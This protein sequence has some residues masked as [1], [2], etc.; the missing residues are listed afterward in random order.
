LTPF[1]DEVEAKFDRS[2]ERL[3]HPVYALDQQLMQSH[4]RT[5]S[6]A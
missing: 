2:A 5:A 4:Q 1:R 3:R 6:S